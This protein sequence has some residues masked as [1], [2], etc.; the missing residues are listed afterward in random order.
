M[1]NRHAFRADHIKIFCRDEADKMLSRG[2]NLQ[3][4]DLLPKVCRCL[5]QLLR[6]DTQ[7]VLLSATMPSQGLEVTTKFIR[8][9]FRILVKRDE[10]TLEGVWLRF[11]THNIGVVTQTAWRELWPQLEYFI[12]NSKLLLATRDTL[13]TVYEVD[14]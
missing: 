8:E 10:L 6:Q 13:R 5:F 9:P 7:I 2:F 1:I 14:I 3:V 12:I 11:A 4:P